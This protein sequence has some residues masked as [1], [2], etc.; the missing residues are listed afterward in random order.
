MSGQRLE[1]KKERLKRY[2]DAEEK[3]LR[4][5]SYKIG[6]R[7]LTRADLESVQ[8]KIKELE[9]EVDALE[10]HGTSKRRS[11]RVVPLG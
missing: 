8:D 7:E 4:G 5:Q 9:A 1:M 6:T 2:Y 3:I 11:A 10:K